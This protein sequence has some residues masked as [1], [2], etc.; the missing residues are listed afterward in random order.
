[1]PQTAQDIQTTE[2]QQPT[3]TNR[4]PPQALPLSGRGKFRFILYICRENG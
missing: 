2:H 1:M 4:A 3:P